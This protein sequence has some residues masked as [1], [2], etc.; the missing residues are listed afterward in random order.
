MEETVDRIATRLATDDD[1]AVIVYTNDPPF[2]RPVEMPYQI[3][4]LSEERAYF[5]A[6]L[7]ES[8]RSQSRLNRRF[9]AEQ[10]Q[11]SRLLLR[12]RIET[13]L[14]A[15]PGDRHILVSFFLTKF[16]FTAQLVA[17]ELGLPH[18]ACIAGSDL[19]RDI[20]SPTG[21]AAAAFVIEH[22]NW[23]VVR[24]REQTERI[25]RLFNR[26]YG[27]SVYNGG[28]PEGRPAGHWK[29]NRNKY[30]SLV[31]DCG[32]SFKKSTHL[33]VDTFGRLL[34]EGYPVTLT[35]VG[36]IQKEQQEYWAAAQQEW[37]DHFVDRASFRGQVAKE[38]VECILLHGDI[39]CSA[40][41]GEGSP[42]GALFALA[43]GMP[44][45]APRS[46]SLADISDPSMDRV[47][48]FRAGDRE[49]FYSRLGAMVSLVRGNLEPVDYERTK[50][51]K[52]R[53]SEEEARHWL[54]VIHSVASA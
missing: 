39:Y 13:R 24:S 52:R 18:I 53:L 25:E 9:S 29:R 35:I 51:I 27:I 8:E 36:K 34:R 38:E 17:R 46:S 40:S 7:M 26:S 21:M 32:Y 44:I 49:D 41:L 45:V 33:L 4:D 16:G 43:L 2:R 42:N 28:L 10:F 50:S 22:A 30:V 31:S 48:L 11:L 6:P 47:S 37:S 12:N 20:A 15:R 14:A 5:S 54:S 19:N 3:E 1:L 23:I